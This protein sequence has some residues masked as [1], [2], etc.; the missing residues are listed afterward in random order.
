MVLMPTSKVDVP[1]KMVSIPQAR[2]R[3]E[4]CGVG[5]VSHS[6]FLSGNLKEPDGTCV[7][8]L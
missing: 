2:G 8:E 3:E 1:K 6:C 5:S 7:F 4:A